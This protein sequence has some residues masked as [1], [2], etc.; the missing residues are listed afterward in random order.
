VVDAIFRAIDYWKAHPEEAD[1]IMAPH[2]QLDSQ[3]FAAILEGVRFCNRA[4]NHEFFG[5]SQSPG[6]IFDVVRRASELWQEAGTI[7]TPVKPES[8]ISLRLTSGE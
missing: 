4:R 6:L 8:I 5:T 2:F 1:A 7:K 3:K